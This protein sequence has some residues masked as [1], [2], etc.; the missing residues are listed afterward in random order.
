MDFQTMNK[1]RKFMLISAGVGTIAMF[2]PWITIS[3]MG[4][5]TGVNGFHDTGILIFLCFIACGVIAFMGNQ[6][7]A[8]D[9]TMWMISLIAAG[10]AALLM[11]IFFLRAMDAISYI[12]YGFYLALVASLALLY[13][14]YMYRSSGFNI[15]DGFD[16]LKND[17][18]KKSNSGN[19]N[20]TNPPL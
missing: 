18:E 5:G 2:L 8:L 17:I 6:T 4:F 13:V 1:Q 10:L 20:N 7:A 16:N 19:T 15:K 11:V 12:S 9:K 3:F 14:I